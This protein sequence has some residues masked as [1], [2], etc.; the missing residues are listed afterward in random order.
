M[1]VE[2]RA[3]LSPDAL[4]GLEANL[5]FGAK[6]PWKR[7]YSGSLSDLANWMFVRPNAVGTDNRCVE[8][9]RHGRRRNSIVNQL[10]NLGCLS[11]GDASCRIS[12]TTR[13]SP[14]TSISPRIRPCSARSSMA[15][16][17][18]ELVARDGAERIQVAQYIFAYRHQRASFGLDAIRSVKMPDYRWGIF[19]PRKWRQKINFG[20]DRGKPL[21]QDV[22]GEHRANLRRIIV[23]QGDTEPASVEQQRRLGLT[24]PSLYD[25]R[26]LFQV[27]V[28]EGR[29]LW[30]MV[31][32]L[33]RYLAGTAVRKPRHSPAPFRPG[34]QS[35]HPGAFNQAT[36]DWLSFF[37]FTYFT[38][39]DG[40]FQLFALA[41]S[42]FEPLA[43][44]TSFMLTEGAHHMYVGETGIAR[45][46]QRTCPVMRQQNV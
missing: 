45:I 22:P 28:E 25:L 21:W 36:P 8:D 37:M 14:I 41:E 43:R 13:T 9:L 31:Y 2:E 33:H 5:R 26:N 19:F 23:T 39:R 12:V 11:A 44:T 18:S 27:N 10:L 4:T 29:H 30:A 42:G 16:G 7:G 34:G 1:A 46:I 6:R 24:A 3:S 32:L 15:A 40:K 38:D 35:T 20:E 17:V